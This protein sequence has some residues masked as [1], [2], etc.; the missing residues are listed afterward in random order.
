ML[1]ALRG[2]LEFM[3]KAEGYEW[4]EGGAETIPEVEKLREFLRSLEQSEEVQA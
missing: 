3:E 4:E 1:A 2:A